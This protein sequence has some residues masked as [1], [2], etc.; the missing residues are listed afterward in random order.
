MALLVVL[1]CPKALTRQM[2]SSYVSQA[3]H[4]I[5][6]YTRVCLDP[7]ST[8]HWSEH[9]AR[10]RVGWGTSS[11][12]HG[13]HS[14]VQCRS[15]LFDI[16]ILQK[17]VATHYSF[18]VYNILISCLPEC[19]TRYYA[20][21]HVQKN[22]VNQNMNQT[23][24]FHKCEFIHTSQHFFME[25]DLC[26]LFANMMVIEEWFFFWESMYKRLIERLHILDT[27]WNW[28]ED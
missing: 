4:S 10:Q 19:H 13:F 17:W 1:V 6:P 22:K 24:Y 27:M 9:A 18:V 8:S 23:Y 14:W 2:C 12:C 7:D 3:F 5:Y 16:V 15:W 28:D 25:K 26:E 20:N 11:C 21:Y